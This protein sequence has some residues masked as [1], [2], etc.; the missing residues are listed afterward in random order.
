MAPL[1]VPISKTRTGTSLGQIS[2]TASTRSS[3]SGRGTRTCSLTIKSSPIKGFI[4]KI[5]ATGYRAALFFIISLYADN[6]V[7]VMGSSK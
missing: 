6:S 7:D 2:K 1:P 5:W 3:V 4:P